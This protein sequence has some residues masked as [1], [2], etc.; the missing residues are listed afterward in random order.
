MLLGAVQ[1]EC[2][3]ACLRGSGDI[4]S[5]STIPAPGLL[6]SI[7]QV[8]IATLIAFKSQKLNQS[9]LG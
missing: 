2:V 8:Y 6:F 5:L 3:S 9:F 4:S 1:A 7:Q